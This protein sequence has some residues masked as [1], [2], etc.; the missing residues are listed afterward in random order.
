VG[1]AAALLERAR[2]LDPDLDLDP[3]AE[4]ARLAGSGDK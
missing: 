1:G 4:A 3:K 2:Q